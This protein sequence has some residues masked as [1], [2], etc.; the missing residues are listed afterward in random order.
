MEYA[1]HATDVGDEEGDADDHGGQ[2]DSEAWGDSDDCQ[3]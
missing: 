2:E 1:S 3:D